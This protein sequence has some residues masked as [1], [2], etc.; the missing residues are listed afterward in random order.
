MQSRR[1][2][3]LGAGTNVVA[4]YVAA[5]ASQFVIFPLFAIAVPVESHF[6]M[7]LWFAVISTVRSYFMRRF[8][9]RGEGR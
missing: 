2:S 7:G 1:H 4:G 3:V 5:V 6:A 8:F 9:A